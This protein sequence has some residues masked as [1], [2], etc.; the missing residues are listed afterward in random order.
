ML[1]DPAKPLPELG[2]ATAV[3]ATGVSGEATSRLV[4]GLAHGGH[5]HA[6]GLTP[7]PVEL[8]TGELLTHDLTI[9][10]KLTGTAIENEDTLAFSV[11]NGIR[12]QIETFP[13]AEAEKAY[14]HMMAGRPRFRVVLDTTA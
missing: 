4:A 8:G 5:L 7:D 3:I 14:E 10:G 1:E 12:A 13:L 9:S 6:V 2:R 11:A